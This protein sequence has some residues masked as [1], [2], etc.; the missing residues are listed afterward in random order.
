VSVIVVGLNHRTVPLDLLERMTV[1]A[2]R[3]PKALHDL[4]SRDNVSEAVLLSTC[5]RTE[6]YALA[7]R[8][9]GAVHDV[10]E[11]L[12]ELA[13]LPPEAFSDHLYTLHDAA[14]AEHLF[15]VAS[16]I[17]SAVPGE[18]EILGQVKE[19]WERAR[20]EGASGPTLNSLFRHA[21]QVGKRSRSETGIA[22]HITSVSQAAV[23]LAEERLGGLGG[24]S[25]LVL[26]A[27]GMAEGMMSVLAAA[28]PAE[29]G[30]ANRTWQR[31]VVLARKAGGVPVRLSDLA[32]ALE[33]AD[34][35]LTSTGSHTVVVERD[36]IEVVV[37]ARRN[38]PL[39]IVDLAVPRDVDP[40]VAELDGVTLL[41]MD[42]IRAFAEAGLAE[43]RR[44]V[45]HVR[46]IITEEV[47]RYVED[48][49]A[50]TVAPLVTAVRRRAE[51]VRRAEVER[52]GRGLDADQRAALDAATKSM[53]AKLLHEPTVRLKEAAGTPRGE[54]LA[55]ALRELF[56]L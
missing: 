43:R 7:E 48:S 47:Q 11:F 45:V 52:L 1:D 35:F 15:A 33:R 17:D 21:L 56:D 28:G 22:R 26:G 54:R 19:A 8:F 13:F 3:L 34:V 5:N 16:G 38:R 31:A 32:D 53:V 44:E 50:R 2:P 51:A 6:V 25:V 39:L 29:V 12:G 37:R 27:G 18:S 9:H 41:D 20:R 23:A 46:R 55:E 30:V 10:R 14:A 49:S 40:G 4:C 42:D 24:R 36:D